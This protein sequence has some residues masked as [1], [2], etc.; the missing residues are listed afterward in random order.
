[1]YDTNILL[2]FDFLINRL[3]IA[4]VINY[5]EIYQLI[6]VVFYNIIFYYLVYCC[7]DFIFYFKLFVYYNYYCLSVSYCICNIFWDWLSLFFIGNVLI[8][9]TSPPFEECNNC[10]NAL[11]FSFMI[12][13]NSIFY[14]L[15]L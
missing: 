5:N 10:C 2:T 15:I 9:P 6:V 11:S 4:V 12:F 8:L 13:F 14:L 3:V 7:N 1:M